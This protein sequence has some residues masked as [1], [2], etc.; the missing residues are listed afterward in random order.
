MNIQEA[1]LLIE[2]RPHRL[3]QSALDVDDVVSLEE[4]VV[5]FDGVIDLQ[6]IELKQVEIIDV[7]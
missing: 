1:N 6:S 4:P 2:D 3:D 7:E 5:V